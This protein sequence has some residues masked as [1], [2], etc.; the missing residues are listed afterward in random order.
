MEGLKLRSFIVAGLMLATAA[1]ATLSTRPQ[2]RKDFR[3]EAWMKK[4]L[5]HTVGNFQMI[6]GTEPDA[7]YRSPQMVYDELR[8]TIGI[9]ARQYQY[10]GQTYDV[11]IIASRDKASFHDPRVCFTAQGYSLQTDEAITLKTKRGE[12]PA[13]LAGLKS[14]NG[15]TITIFFYRG[16]EHFHGTTM[17]LKWSLLF[18]QLKGNEKLDG[19]FYRFVATGEPDRDQLIQF[20]EKFMDE[21][22]KDSDGFF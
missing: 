14:Q 3:D 19:V 10:A 21:A 15:D 5:P 11:N 13:S 8:P 20:V 6:A 12:I 4:V 7:T 2:M 18:N 9:V 16:P 1:W 17:S 22:E